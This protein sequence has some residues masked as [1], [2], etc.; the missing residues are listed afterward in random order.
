MKVVLGTWTTWS[1]S[2]SFIRP[3]RVCVRRTLFFL[4]FR[5]PA[6]LVGACC[7]HP[8]G[9]DHMRSTQAAAAAGRGRGKEGG[10][11]QTR[12][13][14]MGRRKSRPSFPLVDCSLT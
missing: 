3:P 7:R 14:G 2:H 4:L 13:E 1:I 11:T 10:T 9:D 5:P 6:C 8:E 12:Q